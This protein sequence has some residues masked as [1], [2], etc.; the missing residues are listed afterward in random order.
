MAE[1]VRAVGRCGY[2]HRPGRAGPRPLGERVAAEGLPI[3]DVTGLSLRARLAIALRLFAGYCERRG[4]AHPEIAAYLQYLWR[5]VGMPGSPEA[6]GQWEADQ[7]PLVD[8]G[9]GWEY[10]PGFDTI[11]AARGVPEREFRRLICCATE[12]LYS[13]LY[14]AADEPGS[15]RFVAE[16][17][18]QV[19]PLGVPVPDTRPFAGSRWS[20]GHGW[21][22]IP[23]AEELAAW[24]GAGGS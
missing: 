24:Q 6:F 22:A 8:V 1:S 11:L 20:D 2:R 4:L 15:R 7:P 13:S 10:P 17:A 16:L 19:G 9:L 14:G 5:F 23:S 18:A 3:P 12:V 21:G